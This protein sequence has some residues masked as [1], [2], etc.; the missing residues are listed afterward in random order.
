MAVNN[1][2]V[3]WSG[4]EMAGIIVIA[5]GAAFLAYSTYSY[6][7]P[8]TIISHSFNASS[9]GGGNVVSRGGGNFTRGGNFSRTGF[10][11]SPDAFGTPILLR[12]GDILSGILAVL[13]G[14]MLFKYGGLKKRLK[15][16]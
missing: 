4:T 5:L 6:F 7:T 9:F 13:L 8:T 1:A 14:A 3:G 12:I 10:T 16:K 15:S 11:G 2:N